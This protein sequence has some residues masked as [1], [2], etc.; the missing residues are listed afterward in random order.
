LCILK[1]PDILPGGCFLGPLCAVCFCGNWRSELDSLRFRHSDMQDIPTLC[2]KFLYEGLCKISKNLLIITWRLI[3]SPNFHRHL[4]RCHLGCVYNYSS[5]F[6]IFGSTRWSLPALACVVPV[7]IFL[8][9]L[10]W[11]WNATL[12]TGV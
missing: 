9:S 4:W 12:S 8:G 5:N 6:A 7:A 3:L 10:Q 11:I 2:R 1:S